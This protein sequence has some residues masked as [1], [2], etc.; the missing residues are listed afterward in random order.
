MLVKSIVAGTVLTVLAGGV[1]Y[2]G[3]DMSRHIS[4]KSA[5]E[6]T[7]ITAV[8]EKAQAMTDDEIHAEAAAKSAEMIEET[9]EKNSADIPSIKTTKDALID[10]QSDKVKIAEVEADDETNTMQVSMETEDVMS[11]ETE[12]MAEVKTETSPD[13]EASDTK[14]GRKWIDQYLKADPETKAEI[15]A[16][17]KMQAEK[18]KAEAEA[19]TVDAE[20]EAEIDSEMDAEMKKMEAEIVQVEADMAENEKMEAE[21]KIMEAETDSDV[22]PKTLHDILNNHEADAD[23]KDKELHSKNIDIEVTKSEDGT[24]TIEAET[25]DI[26]DDKVIKIVK[27][28]LIS[29]SQ[30]GDEKKIQIKVMTKD[31]FDGDIVPEIINMGDGKKIKIRKK[32]A[33]DP[34]DQIHFEDA[35]SDKTISA[36]TK[37][38]MEQAE[39]I[40]M[41]ELRD[42]AYLDL[43]SYALENGDK[44][45]AN[46]AMSK[47][48]QVELRDTA[49]NRMAVAFAKN[50]HAE[51]AFAILENIEV[52]ALRDVMRLQVI[53]ALIV[54]EEAQSEDMQ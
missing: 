30:D 1:V 17:K 23:S 27:K 43:V 47:I 13:K 41:P 21:M 24:M 50:G 18:A 14:P 10:P 34:R 48:E 33:N 25:I 32:M 39:K 26:G 45:T 19:K 38:I 11:S 53:E 12:I 2:Y 40:S 37:I 49:R 44:K 36:T 4:A 7:K 42:R 51:K 5:D 16:V 46:I 54:P 52:D 9:S 20:M 28:E 3:T 8:D 6:T 15:A 22:T 29:E 31:G 35:G